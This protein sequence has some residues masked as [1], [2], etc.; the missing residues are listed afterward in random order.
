MKD[1]EISQVEN[2]QK[3]LQE[4][5][6]ART[7][8][9]I[10]LEKIKKDHDHVVDTLNSCFVNMQKLQEKQQ[11]HDE[12]RKREMQRAELALEKQ[13]LSHQEKVNELRVEIQRRQ[14]R[15]DQMENILRDNMAT[16]TALRRER[17]E[18]KTALTEAL[19]LKEEL[20]LKLATMEK[21][22]ENS[23][24][25]SQVE[26]NSRLEE[27]RNA[28]ADKDLVVETLEQEVSKCMDKLMNLSEEMETLLHEKSELERKSRAEIEKL[29]QEIWALKEKVSTKEVD[30]TVMSSSISVAAE[31]KAE[32]L[33]ELN[34]LRERVK[35]LEEENAFIMDMELQLD[36]VNFFNSRSSGEQ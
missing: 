35:E 2:L 22:H 1:E 19:S 9:T 13:R 32:F 27:L 26:L 5:R 11:E 16:S 15:L 36:D 12:D 8:L 17:V 6:E 31:E 7:E 34:R 14:E 4:C 21:E 33:S 24:Q 25:D 3:E 18:L 23:A 10:R 29:E 30:I 20:V 28:L